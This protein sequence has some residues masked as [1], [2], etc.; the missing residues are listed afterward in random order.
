MSTH[1]ILLF[2]SELEQHKIIRLGKMHV[3][4]FDIKIHPY[5]RKLAQTFARNRHGHISICK[6]Y[7]GNQW[8]ATDKEIYEYSYPLNWDVFMVRSTTK[9]SFTREQQQ[10]T[11]VN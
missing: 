2:T 6:L 5:P 10:F 11:V 7:S 8:E 9:E 4:N 1:K 3:T